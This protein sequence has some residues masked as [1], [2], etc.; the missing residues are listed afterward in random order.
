MKS[1]EFELNV[2]GKIAH[3]NVLP[4]CSYSR[5]FGMDLLFIH[6][7]KVDFYDKAIEY[8]DDDKEK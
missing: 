4:V 5:I 6:A 8:L 7:T 1:C 3:I 2:M